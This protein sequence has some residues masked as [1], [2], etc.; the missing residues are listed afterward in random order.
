LFPAVVVGPKG[1]WDTGNALRT[2]E[3]TSQALALPAGRWRL[4]LQYFSPFELTL[5][6]PGF[7]RVPEPGLDGQRPNTISLANEGQFWP[8]GEIVSHGGRARFTIT[9]A[10]PSTLQQLSGYDGAAHVG[11]LVAVR[12]GEKRTVALGDACDG[13]ID[14]Y[15]APEVP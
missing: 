9:A 7:P 8:A 13:W 4:S 5:T 15:Q 1:R 12:A 11:N 2:G 3:R 10:D 6:T 14:W